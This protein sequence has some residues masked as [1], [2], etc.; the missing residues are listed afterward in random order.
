MAEPKLLIPDPLLVA[1][2][3]LTKAMDLGSGMAGGPARIVL[4]SCQEKN[5]KIVLD[6][7]I[8]RIIRDT[9]KERNKYE[10]RNTKKS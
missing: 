8:N 3:D 9:N 6:I 1:G 2:I 7:I 4:K 10:N 5:L